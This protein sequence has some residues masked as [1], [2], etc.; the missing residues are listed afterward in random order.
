[1]ASIS[2][3]DLHQFHRTDREVFS[4]LVVK[5]MRNPTESLLVMALWMSLEDIGYPNIIVNMTGL[6]DAMVNALATEAV[7]CLKCLEGNTHGIPLVSVLPLTTIIVHREISLHMFNQKR[8][9]AVS[10]IRSFL[11]NVC[12]RIFT[13]ILE[14]VLGRTSQIIPNVPLVI[15]GF[16]HPLFGSLTIMP[17]KPIGNDIS[18]EKLWGWIPSDDVSMDDK[19]LFLTFSRGF[20]VTKE[21]VI[22]LFSVI[23]GFRVETINM[24]TATSPSSEQP[25]YATMVLD[26]VTTVDQI[27]G[28]KH[29][30]KFRINGKHIWARKYERRE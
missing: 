29:V 2:I 24:G 26:S 9:T 17:N 4:C 12:A 27:L 1:M 14:L 15:P 23:L 13:D 22:E 25:L 6:S 5:L 19:T 10:G 28:G 20:P 3:G 16:P 8:F 7:S 21:E 18:E 30:S 11:N